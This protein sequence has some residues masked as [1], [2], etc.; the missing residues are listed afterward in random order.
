MEIEQY[1]EWVA[2]EFRILQL[3]VRQRQLLNTERFEK[4]KE[5]VIPIQHAILANAVA[6]R[7]DLLDNP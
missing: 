7:Q 1:N 4:I 3:C 6:Q 2:K 5:D